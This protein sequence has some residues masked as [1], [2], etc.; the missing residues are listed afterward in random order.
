MRPYR[1][2][3]RW[4]PDVDTHG[5]EA[6]VRRPPIVRDGFLADPTG[7]QLRGAKVRR[8]ALRSTLAATIVA[9]L[10]TATVLAAPAGTHTQA[11][12][13]TACAALFS[14]SPAIGPEPLSACQWDMRAI[15]A[16][17][18]GSY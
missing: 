5:R 9:L 16:T 3:P 14:V 17:P 4:T 13:I 1:A 11:S 7:P 12:E 8:A 10:M 2:C 6:T 15:G 18:A